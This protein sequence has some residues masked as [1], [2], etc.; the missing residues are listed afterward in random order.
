MALCRL[1]EV[2][3]KY[4]WTFKHV[5]CVVKEDLA[6]S[7][8]AKFQKCLIWSRAGW[9]EDVEGDGGYIIKMGSHQMDRCIDFGECINYNGFLGCCAVCI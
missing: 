3:L 1:S 8:E 4:P 5:Q 9:R 6:D 2:G 7:T